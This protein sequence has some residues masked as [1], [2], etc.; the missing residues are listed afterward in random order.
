MPDEIFDYPVNGVLDLH[1]F[2]PRDVKSVLGEYL[3]ECR[4]RGIL[5]VR[6]IHGKGQGV[7]REIVHS[8][9]KKTP[10][11]LEFRTSTDASGWGA[12]LAVLAPIKQAEDGSQS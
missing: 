12:T 11:V 10:Y 7:L 4:V 9:L 1:M 5:H 3:H 8:F 6:I 2:Q